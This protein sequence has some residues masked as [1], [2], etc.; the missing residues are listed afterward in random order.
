LNYSPLTTFTRS[1]YDREVEGKQMSF[2]H[3]YVSQTREW[4]KFEAKSNVPFSSIVLYVDDY[5]K[6]IVHSQSLKELFL[7]KNTFHSG[8][9]LLTI[10]ATYTIA[11]REFEVYERFMFDV[12]KGT[13]E[14]VREYIQL[15]K[16]GDILVACDNANGLPPGY[17]G[18]SAIVVDPKNLVESVMVNPSIM[19]D[20]IDQF[21]DSHPIHAHYRPKS[22]I[23]GEKA[24]Q[25]ALEYLEKYEDNIAKGIEKPKFSFF[26]ISPLDNPWETIYCSKL[27]WLSY[28]YGADYKF[29]NDYLWFAPQDLEE[30][31]SVDDRFELLYKH[32]NYRFKI[33]L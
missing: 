26:T 7:D 27:V 17:M 22:S 24:A 31:L 14:S 23:A 32:P 8:S 9:H 25:F 2:Q 1:E 28:Y 12:E 5:K 13:T 18:H 4:I 11:G 16:P 30:V 33:D 15:F 21:I 10:V 3:F 29:K 20:T 6:G 19:E